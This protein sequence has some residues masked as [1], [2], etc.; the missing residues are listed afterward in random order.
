MV[1]NFVCSASNPSKEVGV[2]TKTLNLWCDTSEVWLPE[3]YLVKASKKIEWDAMKDK[4][5]YVG[6]IWLLRLILPL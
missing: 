1:I 2:K 6:W 3:T 5:C 4:P